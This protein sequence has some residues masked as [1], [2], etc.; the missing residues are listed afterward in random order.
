MKKI[1]LL[2][3]ICIGAFVAKAQF[4]FNSATSFPVACA[5]VNDGIICWS[6]ING[7]PPYTFNLLGASTT[8]NFNCANNLAAGNYTITA[9]DASGAFITTTITIDVSN[10][11]ISLMSTDD[12]LC[13]G[14]SILLTAEFNSN[15]NIPNNYCTPI[16][17]SANGEDITNVTIDSIINNSTCTSTGIFSSKLNR[18]SNFTDQYTLFTPGELVPFGITIS[19]CS[20]GA[21]NNNV[22]A[23]F[24]DFNI[25]GDFNDLGENVYLSGSVYI[26]GHTE[27]GSFNIPNNLKRGI[28]KMRVMNVNVSSP[29]LVTA[30]GSYPNGEVEDYIVY[31]K[32]MPQVQT[33][34]SSTASSITHY[35]IDA[36]TASDKY[37]YSVDYG[38]GCILLDSILINVLT[39]PVAV[40][41]PTNITCPNASL[42]AVTSGT[43]PFSYLWLPSQESN[44]TISSLNHGVY[45]V[46]VTDSFG[47]TD[48]DSFNYLAVPFMSLSPNIS[49][50]KCKGDSSGNILLNIIGGVPPFTYNWLPIVNGGN[51]NNPYNLSA[52]NYNV[53][54]VDVNG[55]TATGL[56]T[57][58]QPNAALSIVTLGINISAYGANDGSAK[59]I[60]SGG[61]PPYTYLWTPGGQTT[62]SIFNKAPGIYTITVTDANGCKTVDSVKF[63]DAPDNIDN[64]IKNNL[65]DIIPNPAAAECIIKSTQPIQVIRVYNTLGATIHQQSGNNKKE[66][67]LSVQNWPNGIYL[68]SINGI[69]HKQI[70]VAH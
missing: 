50:V 17:A 18:Y 66:Y 33:W 29:S 38:D 69:A 34:F 43:G 53:N 67:T 16:I 15:G 59:V 8:N 48:I 24:I 7:V 47:C 10:P 27:L 12:N 28:S 51:T 11:D 49:N 60:P 65:F 3:L 63:F 20:P 30:C 42:T 45:Y 26:G 44:A 13:I 55:C 58:T 40:I 2:V 52:G 19:N 25:D 23:V 61:T 36:P 31:F 14:D 32:D 64:T 41:T 9:L 68:I 37:Y 62:D 54:V 22:T 1:V 4:Q 21:G 6:V 46:V 56:Y 70:R 35:V 39:P 5:T 57:V